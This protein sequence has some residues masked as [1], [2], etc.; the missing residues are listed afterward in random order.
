[1]SIDQAEMRLEA[2][3]LLK[4]GDVRG[5]IAMYENMLRR[6]PEDHVVLSNLSVALARVGEF[7]KAVQAAEK[8][9]R[10][11]PDGFVKG[12]VQ[13]A[14]AQCSLGM[15]DEARATLDVAFGKCSNEQDR[16][17]VKGIG[18]KLGLVVSITSAE[19]E[20]AKALEAARQELAQ[21]Q[22]QVR[23]AEE[24]RLKA[25]KR[26]ESAEAEITVEEVE[27][28]ES[29]KHALDEASERLT[30]Q[31][32]KEAA[33]APAPPSVAPTEAYTSE[34]PVD[35]TPSDFTVVIEVQLLKDDPKMLVVG[36][37]W[38]GRN[39][40][41]TANNHEDF[42]GIYLK[43]ECSI[44]EY[45]T[46]EADVASTH[47]IRGKIL[48]RAPFKDGVY[49][50]RY[51]TDCSKRVAGVS[52]V[53]QVEKGVVSVDGC[54]NVRYTLVKDPN[55]LCYWL[56][57]PLKQTEGKSVD[58]R[59]T[60]LPAKIMTSNPDR[61]VPTMTLDKES[62]A[63]LTIL[64]PRKFKGLSSSNQTLDFLVP[65]TNITLDDQVDIERSTLSF[66]G[67]D[68][69]ASRLAFL[70]SF[71]AAA[72]REE[73]QL[74]HPSPEELS[75]E[76]YK[77]GI[78]CRQCGSKL[79]N[80]IEDV[81]EAPHLPWA[82][83]LSHLICVPR[84][85]YLGPTTPTY[86]SA[87][88]P[89][90]PQPGVV[91]MHQAFLEFDPANVE[92]GAFQVCAELTDVT[93]NPLLKKQECDTDEKLFYEGIECKNCT[94]W[95][96]IRVGTRS[97]EFK[98]KAIRIYKY[99]VVSPTSSNAFSYYKNSVGPLVGSFITRMSDEQE[100]RKTIIAAKDTDSGK[101]VAFEINLWSADSWM[102]TE[103]MDAMQPVLKVT[104]KPYSGNIDDPELPTLFVTFSQFSD[105]F[106]QL[107]TSTQS[108]P[109]S[110][111]A[112]QDLKVAFIFW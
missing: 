7:K 41:L 104:Y 83:L 84:E 25:E 111:Q 90:K 40:A 76:I 112:F 78:D 31:V 86:F 107:V 54:G 30:E 70:N 94:T 66:H 73:R 47:G 65:Y 35:S 17:A 59:G 68:F 43:E 27:A 24:A 14:N 46:M 91:V 4:A 77:A 56:Y 89:V 74:L 28:Y 50:L 34:L 101:H 32:Q 42:L 33:K 6:S 81:H 85:E 38:I 55:L 58:L 3:R 69:L 39:L 103:S 11:S 71:S 67:G 64:A 108:L 12:Y 29:S 5:A 2:N 9:V 60:R 72:A 87:A 99:C 106:Q 48:I 45:W 15:K 92:S 13:L 57:L 44:D 22:L 80:G 96:G 21:A 75:S 1:M 62:K 100:V 36:W 26:V 109:V 105:L 95:V 10:Y 102:R 20:Y 37:E 110:A 97:D 49:E 88:D 98:L 79:V 53:I 18:N 51:V 8:C 19:V 61:R 23:K 93:N 16:K 82:E 52:Q 63:R